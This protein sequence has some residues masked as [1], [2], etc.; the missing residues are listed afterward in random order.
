MEMQQVQLLVKA[1]IYFFFINICIYENQFAVVQLLISI[2]IK[3]M[4]YVS[5]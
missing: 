5:S 1:I 2:H 4:K 3:I